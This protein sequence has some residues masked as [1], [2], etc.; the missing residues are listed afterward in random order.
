MLGRGKITASRH[1]AMALLSRMLVL[2][3]L[4][5]GLFTLVLTVPAP[6]VEAVEE[7]E[8]VAHP[9]GAGDTALPDDVEHDALTS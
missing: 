3:T 1:D 2:S 5:Y 7:L 9:S 6:E 8:P 4:L